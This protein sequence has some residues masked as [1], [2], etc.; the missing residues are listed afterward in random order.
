[1]SALGVLQI[2][3]H[4]PDVGSSCPNVHDWRAGGEMML[5]ALGGQGFV[6]GFQALMYLA[7]HVAHSSGWDVGRPRK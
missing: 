2:D 5:I 7:C 4:L 3:P 6:R 1:M